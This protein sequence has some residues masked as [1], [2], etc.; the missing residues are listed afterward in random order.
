[1]GAHV[2]VQDGG[3]VQ[4]QLDFLQ[5]VQTFD[6]PG[7]MVVERTVDHRAEALAEF[8]EFDIG[9]GCCRSRRPR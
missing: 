9:L 6:Q 4:Q 3:V 2:R 1:M 8:G 5:A 7:V